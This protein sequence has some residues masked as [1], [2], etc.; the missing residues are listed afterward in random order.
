MANAD[1]QTGRGIVANT[2]LLV[3]N[4]SSNVVINSTSISINGQ[5][6]MNTTNFSGT[7]NNAN[8]LAGTAAF[9][10]TAGLAANVAILTANNANNLGGTAAA[11]FVQNTDSRVLSGNL[12]FSGAN[13]FFDT[14]V[15][16]GANT[17]VNTSLIKVGNSSQF[18]QMNSS[19]ISVSGTTANG[20]ANL[21]TY[22]ANTLNKIIRI[23]DMHAA[24][25]YVTIPDSD[26]ITWDMSLGTNFY[27]HPAAARTLS[28]PI[29]FP[30][31]MTGYLWFQQ[32]AG[33]GAFFSWHSSYRFDQFVTQ[34]PNTSPNV[35]TIYTWHAHPVGVMLMSRVWSGAI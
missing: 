32:P 30:T 5:L 3:G 17:V 10:T 24:A 21:T 25:Q 29:N 16:V 34:Q 31:G 6:I 26:P 19:V 28:F 23:E 4:S 20:F 8:N 22:A 1:F 18:L 35:S 9:Q 15:F 11:S 7:A 27:V 13:N 14:A 2:Q 12:H 33:G